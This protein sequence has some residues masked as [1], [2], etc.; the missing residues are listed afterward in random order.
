MRPGRKMTAGTCHLPWNDPS[1]RTS[2]LRLPLVS[3]GLTDAAWRI[4]A[5]RARRGSRTRKDGAQ[6]KAETAASV[7]VSPLLSPSSPNSGDTD[8]E[9]LDLLR[10]LLGA[11]VIATG[12]L[13]VTGPQPLRLVHNCVRS[14]RKP[15]MRQV[16]RPPRRATLLSEIIR[17]S[18]TTL[19]APFPQ[20]DIRRI[21]GN[22]PLSLIERY[23]HHALVEAKRVVRRAVGRWRCLLRRV[24]SAIGGGADRSAAAPAEGSG[25]E[26]GQLL[27]GPG[28]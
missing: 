7:I 24:R 21:R 26:A 20:D 15:A 2:A 9:A 25:V 5:Q 8:T 1:S 14:R 6:A 22:G 27:V 13:P 23:W 4:S 10:D 18:R 17:R 16:P 19:R 11:E 12:P 3:A 28:G